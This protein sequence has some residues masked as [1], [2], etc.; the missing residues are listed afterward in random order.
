MKHNIAVTFELLFWTAVA[1]MFGFI[2]APR[3]LQ[4]QTEQ[5]PVSPLTFVFIV[6]GIML[7]AAYVWLK[8]FKKLSSDMLVG[9]FSGGIG[10]IMYRA[11][12]ALFPF[13][14]DSATIDI[15]LALLIIYG[16]GF[17]FYYLV[18]HM[19]KSWKNTQRWYSLVNLIMVAVIPVVAVIMSKGIPL[20]AAMILLFLIACYDAYAV[21]KSKHMIELA[22]T[23]MKLR[24]L[25]GIV[26][27]RKE[28]DQFAILGGGDIF[29]IS[30]VSASAY[31]TSS[32]AAIAV[33]IGGFAAII[34]LFLA[35]KKKKFYPAIPFILVGIGLGLAIEWAIRVLL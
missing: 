28:K 14:T 8:L 15:I 5:L 11:I 25:P 30:F 19:Q 18:K 4:K 32:F 27:P 10:A 20:W 34:Y 29:F 1:L 9:V 33:L 23:F 12:K 31:A 3:I 21:W 17:G 24:I 26:V 6:V 16:C 35:S 13:T 22:K 2:T 7:V